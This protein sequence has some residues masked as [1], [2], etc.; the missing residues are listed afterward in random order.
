MA[1]RVRV[2]ARKWQGD[3]AYSWAVFLD[4]RVRTDLSG[5]SRSQARYYVAMVRKQIGVL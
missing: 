4:G 3:D 2:T 5:L 1:T